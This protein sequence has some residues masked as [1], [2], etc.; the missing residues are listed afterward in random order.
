MALTE[1]KIKNIVEGFIASL[2]DEINVE[3]VILFGSYAKGEAWAALVQYLN[4]NDSKLST[5]HIPAGPENTSYRCLC[6]G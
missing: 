2:S 5:L 3:E 4:F 1:D 6:R